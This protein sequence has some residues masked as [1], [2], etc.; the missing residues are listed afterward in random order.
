MNGSRHSSRKSYATFGSFDSV[1]NRQSTPNGLY[2][3]ASRMSNQTMDSNQ[4][5][6]T[7]DNLD[8]FKINNPDIGVTITGQNNGPPRHHKMN[9]YQQQYEREQSANDQHPL[10]KQYQFKQPPPKSHAPQQKPQQPRMPPKQQIHRGTAPPMPN[11]NR[12]SYFGNIDE[13]RIENPE[14]GERVV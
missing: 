4:V 11:K 13:F 1:Q 9:P 3:T 10:H 2:S 7:Q 14:I 8:N 12:Q 5:V 6:N